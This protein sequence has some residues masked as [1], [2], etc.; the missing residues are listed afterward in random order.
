MY[1]PFHRPPSGTLL[2]C[3]S[4]FPVLRSF[5]ARADSGSCHRFFTSLLRKE[6]VCE[7]ALE[8]TTVGGS[9]HHCSER[10]MFMATALLVAHCGA[11]E[12]SRE[13]LERVEA[14]KAT[15]TWF[16]VK[17]AVGHQQ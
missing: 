17:H 14:P 3:P 1:G 16:P 13:E 11:R 10:S 5:R 6:Q 9:S 12:L 8:R 4:G 2:P 15:D 7:A